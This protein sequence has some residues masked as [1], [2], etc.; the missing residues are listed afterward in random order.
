VPFVHV[1]TDYVFDGTKA[2]PYLEADEPNPLGVYGA[3]KLA[4]DC[5]I[6]EAADVPYAILRASWV[7]SH[8]GETFPRKILRRARQQASLRVVNDQWGCPTPADDL[9]LAMVEMKAG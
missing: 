2:G 1:S 5:A 3:S 9:A 8:V 4:G 7:F 6:A